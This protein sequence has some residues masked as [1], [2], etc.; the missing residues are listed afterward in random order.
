MFRWLFFIAIILSSPL[1]AGEHIFISGGPA[2]RT[3]ERYK[4]NDHDRYWGNFIDSVVAR[5]Q[6]VKSS[7]SP[8]DSITW[9]VFRT[10]YETRA[11]EENTDYFPRIQSKAEAMGARLVYFE[12][13]DELIDYINKGQD[14]KQIK[15][16]RLEYFGHSNKRC[17]MFDYSNLLDGAGPDYGMLHL[18]DLK[19]IRSE[20][21]SPDAHCQSWGCH[22]GEEYSAVWF[23]QTRVRMVGAIGKTDYSKGGVPILSRPENTWSQ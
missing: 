5:H 11:R 15:I 3:Y 20:S 13:R 22:S 17:F 8:D 9:L 21:F 14:R 2:L 10:G 18:D 6:Q 12:T 23:K 4:K 7:Y 16:E 19:N 1:A